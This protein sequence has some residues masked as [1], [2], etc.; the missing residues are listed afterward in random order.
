MLANILWISSALNLLVN[1]I[2]MSCCSQMH[3]LSHIL[4]I[5]KNK[6]INK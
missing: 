2:L 6:C 5:L 4:L 1:I 3:K